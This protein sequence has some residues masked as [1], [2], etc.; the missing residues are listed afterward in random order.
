MVAKSDYYD[1]LGVSRSA[2]SEEMKKAYRKKA[3]EWHPDRHKGGDKEEAEKRF[4]EINEAYQILSDS[5]KKAAYDQYGHSAFSPGGA[6]SGFSGQNP[7]SRGGQGGPFTYTYTSQGGESPFSGFDF[8]D[9][10]DIFESFFGGGSPSGRTQRKPRYSLTV[11]FM[12][13]VNGVEKTVEIGG[14]K[15]SIKIPA[16]ISEGTRI[17]FNDFILSVDIHPH[18]LFER[19]G[20]DIYIREIIPF[21]L[22]ALG[23]E[24]EV[25]T[26]SGK[27]K[28]R[29]RPGTQS[30]TMIRLQGKGVVHVRGRGR[31]DE[32]VRLN[33]LVPEKINREQKELLE[34]L[35]DTN[36]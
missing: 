17:E 27:I 8:S 21:S 36:L 15:R 18:E 19:D 35:K 6:A 33:I 22:A 2:S 7:F 25:P 4:K 3:L 1:I 5:Q 26:V 28:I 31:G 16:G 34:E 13:A 9:P 29:V 10:F 14:K 23:G 12:E 20:D 11:D 24:I 30:G 32:Y